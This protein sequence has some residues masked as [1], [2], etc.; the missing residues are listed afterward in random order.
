MK[1]WEEHKPSEKD[2]RETLK[3]LRQQV[4]EESKKHPIDL[5]A[6]EKEK[7][8]LDEIMRKIKGFKPGPLNL[9]KAVFK[10]T[11]RE[12]TDFSEEGIHSQKEKKEDITYDSKRKPRNVKGDPLLDALDG[13][14]VQEESESETDDSSEDLALDKRERPKDADKPLDQKDLERFDIMSSPNGAMTY[15][16]MNAYIRF[17]RKKFRQGQF[18]DKPWLIEDEFYFEDMKEPIKSS[19]LKKFKRDLLTY[20]RIFFPMLTFNRWH[21]VLVEIN[22]EDPENPVVIYRDPPHR[23]DY[24]EYD[25][26]IQNAIKNAGTGWEGYGSKFENSKI[27]KQFDSYNCGIHCLKNLSDIILRGDTGVYSKNHKEFAASNKEIF[28]GWRQKFKQAII[29]DQNGKPPLTSTPP[30]KYTP[31]VTNTP[32]P[33]SSSSQ[34]GT[35]SGTQTQEPFKMTFSLSSSSPTMPSELLQTTQGQ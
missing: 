20:K 26:V 13:K 25:D 33:P 35:Q 11:E 6:K 22:S 16:Q 18:K 10:P 28:K 31:Q 27:S 24:T 30:D 3:K 34:S 21:Y 9:E 8:P 5:D 15:R 14:P 2:K 12:I 29:D 19:F 32:S 4:A 7:V 1:K 23:K 17:L